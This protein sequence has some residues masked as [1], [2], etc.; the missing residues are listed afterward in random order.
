M[1]DITDA[2]TAATLRAHAAVERLDA[3][4]LADLIRLYKAAAQEIGRRIR[5]AA[6]RDETV[7]IAEMRRLRDQ[8]EAILAAL[9]AQ[10]DQMIIGNMTIAANYGVAPWDTVAVAQKQTLPVSVAQRQVAQRA[11]A[12]VRNFIAQDG[13]QL[14][15]RLWRA[16][17]AGRDLIINTIERAVVMG[18]S[19]TE[20]ARDLLVRGAPLTGDISNKLKGAGAARLSNQVEALMAGEGG[21]LHK[22]TRLMRTEINRAH[23]EAYMMGGEDH[24]DFGGWIYKLSAAHPRPDICDLLAAQNL[25]GLGP[26]VYPNREVLPWPAHPNTLSFIATK[27]KDQVTEKDRAGKETQAEALGRLSAEKRE[28]VL[29][30][31]RA[32]AFNEGGFRRDMLPEQFRAG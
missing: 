7:S 17:R 11:V 20:A 19:A 10:R 8:V 5:A 26:G 16:D 29:G 31:S 4:A 27:W 1:S 9:S 18:Q 28:G 24:P 23:G 25:Y 12:F 15:D 6:G 30:K 3:D 21:P 14:S 22:A 2:I 13:L 32:E